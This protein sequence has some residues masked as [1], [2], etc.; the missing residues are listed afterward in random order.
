M[1]EEVGGE[2]KSPTSDASSTAASSP[3]AAYAGLTLDNEN[4]GEHSGSESQGYQDNTRLSAVQ[5]IRN[6][7]AEISRSSS[8]AKRTAS[9][10]E[11][12]QDSQ[13]SED[14][15][16]VDGTPMVLGTQDDIVGP[17]QKANKAKKVTHNQSSRHNREVSVDMLASELDKSSDLEQE[18]STLDD[19]PENATNGAYLTP[20]SGTS[21][22][23]STTAVSDTSVALSKSRS[24]DLPPIDEQINKVMSLILQPMEAGRK[25]FIVAKKWL[26]KVQARGTEAQHDV[27][28]VKTQWEEE[29]GP[30][31]NTGI[32]LIADPS[33]GDFK[34]EAGELFIPLTPGLVMGEDIEILPR[35][36]W[37]LIVK[38]YGLAKG[39]PVIARYCHNTSTSKTQ[40]NVQ[41]ELYPPIFTLLKLPDQ[42]QGLTRASMA[43]KD[44]KPIKLLS[45]RHEDFQKFLTRAKTAAGIDMDTRVRVWRILGGLGSN[46]QPGMITPAQS[47]SA[48]PAPNMGQP[49]E[50]GD[51]L[52]LDVYAF[53]GLQE[54]SQRE[55]LEIKDETM[56]HKYTGT[57][58]LGVVGLGKDDVV[59]LE[60][61]I[62]GPAG[63]EWVSNTANTNAAKNG[64]IPV[65]VTKDGVTTVQN[66]LKSKA[67][68][69]NA[70]K[71]SPA[72]GGMMTRGRALKSGRT[73]GTV[74][75]SNL[76]NSCYMNSAL[77]CVRSV[78]ELTQYFLLGHYKH[79][80]NPRNPLAHNGE[81][82]KVY[83]NLLGELYSES[84]SSSFSPR[85][86]KQ[87]MGKYGP[88]FSG[89]G[90]QD[91]Q[92]FLL[93]LLDGLQ[94]DLNRIH[95]K[96]YIEKP[97][98]TDEMVNNPDL[99]RELA[100][101]CWD[102][103]KARNDSVITDLFAG[104]YKSTLVCPVCD[105]VNISFDPFN[106]LTLQLPIENLWSR[107]LYYFPL[108][109]RPVRIS[110]D[111]DKG[112]SFMALKENVGKK[113]QV[114]PKKLIV[115]EIYKHR[116]F[117]MFD[118]S[119]SINDERIA[120]GDS[121]GV[122]ELD[123]VPTNH[124]APKKKGQKTQRSM[125]FTSYGNHDEEEDIPTGNSPMAEKMLVPVFNRVEKESS[126]RSSQKTLFG[127]PSYIVLTRE[128]AIDYD[129]ILRKVLGKIGTMT[130][131]DVLGDDDGSEE[132]SSRQEE[133]D[134]VLMTNSDID[135]S[136]DS[137][138][139]A[140]SLQ[141]EDGMVD[142]SMNDASA[143]LT[144][145]PRISYP[146][147]SQ[148]K[149]RL[150]KV[151]R[152]GEF[153]KPELRRL[154]EMRFF[155]GKSASEMVPTGWNQLQEESKNYPALSSR[156]AQESQPRRRNP[157]TQL[158]RRIANGGS[159]SESDEDVDDAP[160]AAHMSNAYDE[161]SASDGLPD[162]ENI[163][164][165]RNAVFSRF[166]RR[167][168]RNKSGLI[169]YPHK[170]KHAGKSRLDDEMGTDMERKNEPLL[171][172]GDAILLDWNSESHD[173]LFTGAP[174][175]KDSDMRGAATWD[176]IPIRPDPEL[177]Q[178]RQLR[179]ARK[180]NGVSLGDCLDEF[181]KAEILSENDAWYCP[182]CKKHRRASKK[183]E[184]WKSPDILVIHL[185]RFSAQGRLRDKIDVLVDF[186]VEG[187]DLS[188]RVVIQESDESPI[189]DLFAV[190]NHYGGLGGGHY[191][192]FAKNFFD[193]DWYEYNG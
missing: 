189:Y 47:R 2:G 110:I 112:A 86:F 20:Q 8:P 106:N 96:P 63:G 104:M 164:S 136:S 128:E 126:Y 40:E 101:K 67:N 43:E 135:S 65:S 7:R 188:S 79:E 59:V 16:M 12:L 35:E 132:G 25:G 160:T 130:S 41:Y 166:N 150:P 151:M 154:F 93:F 129:A 45:S 6:R 181:G 119:G 81:V 170:D 174:G 192:A 107:N 137:K 147:Q 21:S 169:K 145:P 182:R 9:E 120:D 158:T 48:S 109:S 78:E 121:I 185:K 82:A 131:L 56:K 30:V 36:A 38:W 139:Q 165:V 95:K 4:R 87:V 178:K 88:S 190:D 62:G 102:I 69:G 54:A 186:P 172:L 97:D 100:D 143:E 75:L 77:Q 32:G 168:K 33:L 23:G 51:R 18:E 60:E 149:T 76:G 31:D 24:D 64:V 116:F 80:L 15:G 5:V 187:L 123:M 70:R 155:S 108:R 118:D 58:D 140:N 11:S 13:T 74:G 14:V 39:S 1:F 73:Q 99:L 55:L 50:H 159:S 183:F 176:D 19:T 94:E 98:S 34:D 89:Y 52:V 85:Q 134:T 44:A 53:I 29:I 68:I 180:R 152:P 3:S 92:E 193:G 173:A 49:I 127:V 148:C 125:L 84:A 114:D 142:I 105:K 91:S 61:Q 28:Y 111:I 138:V 10:M 17:M 156:M 175:D 113:V 26:S 115:A 161:D 167:T 177:E 57:S 66:Q 22:T 90:Q 141:S 122:F 133:S 157:R 42:T 163:T 27:R 72:P 171:Q 37:D 124:P 83:A 71:L 179:V 184:L 146:P 162:V 153:I 191:T 117:K 144:Q 46:D 103:Y